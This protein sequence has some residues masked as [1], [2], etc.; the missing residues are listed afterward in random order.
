MLKA[1][2][3]IILVLCSSVSLFSQNESGVR[4]IDHLT[5]NPPFSVFH[6]GVPIIRSIPP[7]SMSMP[8]EVLIGYIAM[9]SIGRFYN[10]SAFRAVRGKSLR[11]ALYDLEPTDDTLQT[12]WK[13]L[14]KMIDYDP[15]KYNQFE[16]QQSINQP[17]N[18]F[19][20]MLFGKILLEGSYKFDHPLK[21]RIASALVPDYIL[22]VQVVSIDSM[23]ATFSSF[24]DTSSYDD[25]KITCIVLDTIKGKVIPMDTISISESIKNKEEVKSVTYRFNFIVSKNSYFQIRMLD[26]YNHPF[27]NV[28]SLIYDKTRKIMRVHHGQE[29]L[30]SLNLFNTLWSKT[31]D[32]FQFSI[33]PLACQGVF[34][35]V[36]G[37]VSD[38]N[39]VWSDSTWVPY[40]TFKQRYNE[41]VE[42]I[43]N[44]D[45]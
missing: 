38:V 40:E 44:K 1:I 11:D 21:K 16:S 12:I 25:F 30:I 34:P 45:Y 19:R 26:K 37:M 41:T 10:D 20:S 3:V 8:V 5:D 23:K 13:Y 32:Y 27:P 6:T 2:Y 42:I 31:H 22:R 7:L 43:M 33:V 9:D 28:D 15:L 18:Y 17:T 29:L 35:I 14:Y 4:N 24:G 39:K 36:N